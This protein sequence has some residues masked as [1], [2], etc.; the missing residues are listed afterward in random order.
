METWR[1]L[2]TEMW[3]LREMWWSGVFALA[4]FVHLIRAIIGLPLTVG[5]VSVP[6]WLSWIVASLAGLASGWLM[7][8]ALTADTCCHT[9][10]AG[11]EFAEAGSMPVTSCQGDRR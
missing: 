3:R 2:T 1:I 7:Q 6:V 10:R 8:R 4:A 9:A 5:T 11:E